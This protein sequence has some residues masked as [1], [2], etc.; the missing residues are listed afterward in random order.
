[1]NFVT[2]EDFVTLVGKSRRTIDRRIQAY[3]KKNPKRF[4]KLM[5]KE[6][7]RVFYDPRLVEEIGMRADI[8]RKIASELDGE[9]ADDLER[10]SD[11]VITNVKPV[12]R[13]DKDEYRLFRSV[14]TDFRTGIY[15]LIEACE[16]HLL[17][18]GTFL[19][20]IDARP[21]YKDLY[22]ECYSAHKVAFAIT[23][24]EA[25]KKGLRDVITGYDKKLETVTYD[26][27]MSPTGQEILIV[28][29]R[30]VQTK[31]VMPNVTAMAFAL[32]N[33]DPDEWRR[34]FGRDYKRD[35]KDQNP[36]DAMNKDQLMD[37]LKECDKLGFLRDGEGQQ[38]S[39]GQI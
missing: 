1:M 17:A 22:D 15:T 35:E 2:I 20:W 5:K 33:R 13:G 28:K 6:G 18:P 11:I 26:A 12:D 19:S 21:S 4:A 9:P 24:R 34:S 27:K 7:A 16:N 39:S 30:R 23:L 37:Y 36:I 25:A 14:L 32:T 10:E 38:V 31:H 29:E 3:A 8:M